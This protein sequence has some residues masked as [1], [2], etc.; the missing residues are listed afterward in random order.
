MSSL[1]ADVHHISLMANCAA[2]SILTLAPLRRS[3]RTVAQRHAIEGVIFRRRSGVPVAR[4]LTHRK[5]TCR[6]AA[7]LYL[8]PPPQEILEQVDAAPSIAVADVVAGRVNL[9]QFGAGDAIAHLLIGAGMP[10]LLL[11]CP[12]RSRR[13]TR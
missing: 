3:P 1:R 11:P 13:T 2:Y 10:D 12:R 4:C 6:A 7:Q 9:A 8:A 5:L